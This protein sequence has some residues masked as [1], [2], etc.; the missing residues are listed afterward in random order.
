MFTLLRN[1]IV[2]AQKEEK[3]DSAPS[4]MTIFYKWLWRESTLIFLSCST[5]TNY[6]ESPS[7]S[8]SVAATV[9]L[10]LSPR[11]RRCMS[12][13]LPHL[14]FKERA[15]HLSITRSPGRSAELC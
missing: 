4:D 1:L 2:T 9:F 6:A 15:K 5:K 12:H 3:Y 8:D 13:P 7:V 10:S 11:L 14:L